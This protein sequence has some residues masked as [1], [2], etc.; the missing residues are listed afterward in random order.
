MELD[1]S[2]KDNLSGSC[3]K[4]PKGGSDERNPIVEHFT[5]YCIKVRSW[6]V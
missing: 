6:E 1:N 5:G 3:F 2:T 4:N